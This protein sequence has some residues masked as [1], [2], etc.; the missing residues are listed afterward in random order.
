MGWI[1]IKKFGFLLNTRV[2]LFIDKQRTGEWLFCQK[3][4]LK[5]VDRWRFFNFF[6]YLYDHF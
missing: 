3:M 6:V 5:Q 1:L 2:P 4:V